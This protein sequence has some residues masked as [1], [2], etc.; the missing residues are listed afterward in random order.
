MRAAEMMAGFDPEE[1]DWV[2]TP[3]VLSRG[4]AGLG[5]TDS[6]RTPEEV[7]QVRT[8]RA[9][10]EALQAGVAGAIPNMARQEA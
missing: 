2:K 8:E 5:F 7:Q 6:I 1:R 3:S 4:M 10:R 9:E